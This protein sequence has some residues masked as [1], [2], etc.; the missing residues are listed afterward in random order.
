[1]VKIKIEWA[2]DSV[3]MFEENEGGEVCRERFSAKPYQFG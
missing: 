1:M 2:K 3:G